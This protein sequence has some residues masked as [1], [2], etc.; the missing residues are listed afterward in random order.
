MYP[1]NFKRPIPLKVWM[2][3][4]GLS[5][6]KT[7]KFFADGDNFFIPASIQKMIANENR[8]VGVLDETLVETVRQEVVGA[9]AEG[10]HLDVQEIIYIKPIKPRKKLGPN[11]NAKPRGP[12]PSVKS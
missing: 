9:F 10:R 6:P 3:S 2:D 1:P 11:P 5:I 12:R 7:A 8:D 4:K